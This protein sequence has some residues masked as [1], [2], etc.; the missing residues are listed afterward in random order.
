MAIQIGGSKAWIVRLHGDIGVSFQWVNDEPAMILFP[1]KKSSIGAGAF[2]LCLSAAHRYADSKTGGPT[3]YLIRS[4]A[5]AAGQMG[6]MQ[7]DTFVIRKIADVILDSLP[8]L[9]AMPPEPQQFNKEQTDTVGE[10][11]I[12][13]NGETIV[14]QEVSMPQQSEMA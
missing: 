4:A 13:M 1:A 8:D 10:M 6:F 3:P 11:L 14:H 12:K 7:T 9:I 5:M 2:V